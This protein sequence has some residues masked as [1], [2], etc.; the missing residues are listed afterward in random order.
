MRKAITYAEGPYLSLRIDHDYLSVGEMGNILIR[1]QATLR[2][3]ADLG[4]GGREQPRFIISSIKEAHSL[5]IVVRLSILTVAAQIPHNLD[6]YREVAGQAFQRFMLSAAA[7][8]KDSGLK[9]T[10]TKGEVDWKLPRKS[11]GEPNLRQRKKLTDF[12]GAL[13]RPA[14][15]VVIKDEDSEITLK[16]PD[17]PKLL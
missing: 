8:A 1:L 9:I 12:I 14:N 13:T 16:R 4:R 10:A 17:L 5:E 15:S 3:L 2:S 6:F 11:R 7:I